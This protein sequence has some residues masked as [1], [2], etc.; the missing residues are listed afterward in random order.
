[1]LQHVPPGILQRQLVKAWN[2]P[3]P[4][5]QPVQVG[6]EYR[7]PGHSQQ[8]TPAAD[9]PSPAPGHQARQRTADDPQGRYD[10]H[11]QHVLGHVR[12]G[13]G[14]GPVIQRTHHGKQCQG[15]TQMKCCRTPAGRRSATCAQQ[16]EQPDRAQN[17]HPQQDRYS[18]LQRTGC[19]A[20]GQCRHTHTAQQPCQRRDAP[21]HATHVHGGSIRAGMATARVAKAPIR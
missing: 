9:Q 6:H 5:R 4:D 7:V 14:L 16:V 8:G 11:E 2:M 13:T 19:R 1:M 21:G 12:A 15:R 17:E 20:V 18:L 10:P 3:E